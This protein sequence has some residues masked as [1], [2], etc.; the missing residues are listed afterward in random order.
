MKAPSKKA[1]AMI[2]LIFAIVIV[3]IAMLSVPNLITTSTNSSFVALQQESIN[4]AATK[5]NTILS[6][7]WDE[8]D[9]DPKFID[10]ILVVSNSSSSDL[11]EN[12]TTGRRKGTP[13][14]SDRS[15]I[16]ADGA[17]LN[18]STTLGLDSN[19]GGT[20]DDMDDF[21]GEN[22]SLVQIQ[23]S[24]ND[25]VDKNIS[26]STSVKYIADANGNFGAKII[27]YNPNFGSTATGT[28][29]IKAISVTL[30]SSSGVKE[31]NKQ[32]VFHAFGCNIG[33]TELVERK[34]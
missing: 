30:T 1:I 22:V 7:H 17:R 23:T 26:I 8:Q 34:F 12:G 9:T 13:K 27:N 21:N 31:L 3:G 15:F 2:E 10:P 6:Y 28:T 16:R 18:A 24:N 5:L 14:E 11:D 32:I 25:Y 29:N 20:K 4:E 19:D 33:A